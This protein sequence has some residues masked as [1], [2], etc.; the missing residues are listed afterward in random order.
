MSR[1]RY[2]TLANAK[3]VSCAVEALRA[4][5]HIVEVGELN[6]KAVLTVDG[7]ALVL[8]SGLIDEQLRRA[9]AQCEDARVH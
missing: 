2:A 1:A 8:D 6:G 4:L 7:E 5:G 3:A 9:A